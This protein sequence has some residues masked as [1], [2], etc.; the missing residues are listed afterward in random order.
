MRLRSA[1]VA[2]LPLLLIACSDMAGAA[3]HSW[4]VTDF[5]KIRVEGPFDVRVHAGQPAG[6]HASGSQGAID[7]LVVEQHGDTLVIHADRTAGWDFHVST[8]KMIVEVGTRVLNGATLAGSGDLSVD[9]MRGDAVDLSLTG[10]GDLT[11]GDLA[12]AQT[13]ISLTGPGDLTVA[14]R[15]RAATALVTGSGDLHGG[16]L[17]AGDAT[18]TLVGSGDLEVGASGNAAVKLAGSGDISIVGPARCTVDRSGSG[19]VR[20]AHQNSSAD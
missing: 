8:E 3:T 15:T 9:H 17:A 20:C 19:D 13:R 12:A 11:I 2:A 7:R 1:T 6:V 16:K 4:Q 14:G 10:S 18:V 5:S